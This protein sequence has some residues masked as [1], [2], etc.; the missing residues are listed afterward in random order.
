MF[1]EA[2]K[3]AA[4]S[5]VSRAGAWAPLPGA[6][7]VWFGVRLMGYQIVAPETW[8]QGIAAFLLCA[9]AAWVIIF[10]GRLLYW[11][12]RE[13]RIARRRLARALS[14]TLAYLSNRD[15]E[16][17]WAISQMAHRSAWGRWYSAQSLATSGVP[18]REDSLLSIASSV[19]IEKII[20]G[21]LEVRGRQLGNIKYETIPR[22]D[23]RSSALHFVK[24]PR[25][26]W[27]MIIIPRGGAEITPEG[28]VI[29]HNAVAAQR[30]ARLCNYDSLIVDSYQFENLWPEKDEPADKLRRRFLRAARRRSLDQTEIQRLS[31]L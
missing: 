23:W 25:T 31:S 24:D 1:F 27:K 26:L 10:V 12:Y 3:Y 7:I 15:S 11:P 18:I 14:R 16:L 30:N 4:K 19:V 29:A 2:I 6:L 22:T 17:G 21:E 8:E 5:S 20:D 28:T 13:L 9:A